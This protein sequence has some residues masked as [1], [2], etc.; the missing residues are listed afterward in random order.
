[1]FEHNLINFFSETEPSIITLLCY[2]LIKN[3]WI[4]VLINQSNPM[5]TIIIKLKK[6]KAE[7]IYL[8]LLD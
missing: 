4:E 1:M 3:I 5:Q 7:K 8:F 2:A 6:S